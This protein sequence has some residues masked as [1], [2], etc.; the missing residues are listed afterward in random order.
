MEEKLNELEEIVDKFCK[1]NDIGYVLIATAENG[2]YEKLVMS[3]TN[4]VLE[5]ARKVLKTVLSR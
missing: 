5:E 3:L 4:G 1:G 2:K